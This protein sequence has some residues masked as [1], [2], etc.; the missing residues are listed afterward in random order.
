MTKDEFIKEGCPGDILAPVKEWA[1][2]PLPDTCKLK[3][4]QEWASGVTTAASELME[5]SNGNT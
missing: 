1:E 4:W 3:R 2:Q 5:E